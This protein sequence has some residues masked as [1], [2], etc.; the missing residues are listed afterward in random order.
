MSRRRRRIGEVWWVDG[1]EQ[2]RDKGGRAAEEKETYFDFNTRL[3]WGRGGGG[4]REPKSMKCCCKSNVVSA[5]LAAFNGNWGKSKSNISASHIPFA[6]S[7]C[8]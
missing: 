2:Q 4:S 6:I 1:R 5:Q 8:I 7:I 3:I